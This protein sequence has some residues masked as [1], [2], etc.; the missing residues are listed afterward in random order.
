MAGNWK[1]HEDQRVL[2]KWKYIFTIISIIALII[3][4]AYTILRAISFPV[5]THDN[6]FILMDT[7]TQANI[8]IDREN[9]TYMILDEHYLDSCI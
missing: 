9:N 5:H 3:F 6:A 8:A 7:Y 4:L 2:F 1:I